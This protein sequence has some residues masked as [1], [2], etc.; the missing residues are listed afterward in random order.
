MD[1]FVIN[2][3]N[4]DNIKPELLEEFR[5]KKITNRKKLREHC[6][7]YLMLDRILKEVYKIEN[8]ELEFVN[9]KPYLKNRQKYF[10]LSHSGDYIVIVF[11][12]FD[13]GVDIEKIKS[14]DFVAISQRMNFDSKTLKEFYYEWTKYEAEYKSG[15]ETK[16]IKQTNIGDYALTAVSTGIEES[17]EIYIQSGETFPN[18]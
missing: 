18:L 9:N 3:N 17:F 16:S 13:C 5:H 10:S 15:A 8:Y 2:T 12:A 11:S 6:L 7:S 14:R 1:I 4:A